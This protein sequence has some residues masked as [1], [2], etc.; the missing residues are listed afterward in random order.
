MGLARES[1]V[2]LPHVT[3]T[4]HTTYSNGMARELQIRLQHVVEKLL[5]PKKKRTNERPTKNADTG[6]LTGGSH[7]E[8]YPDVA[9][10]EDNVRAYTLGPT[11]QRMPNIIAP[12]ASAKSGP[13]LDEHME[14][15]RDAVNVSLKSRYPTFLLLNRL[16]RLGLESRWTAFAQLP[17]NM[18]NLS[19]Y[20]QKL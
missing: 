8:R 9:P 13:T 1:L 14:I 5:G 7:F 18:L 20:S 15:H 4:Q 12:A 10:V 11:H 19:R 17:R 3:L 6:E 16:R 2:T